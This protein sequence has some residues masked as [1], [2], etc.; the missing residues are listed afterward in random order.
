LVPSNSSPVS[1]FLRDGVLK[2]GLETARAIA[3]FLPHPVPVVV[4]TS[5]R[6]RGV[7]L[8]FL[9]EQGLEVVTAPGIPAD[10]LIQAVGQ[11]REWMARVCERLAAEGA[12]PGGPPAPRPK[13]LVLTAFHQ[14]F[15]V[16][17]L[18]KKQSGCLLMVRGPDAVMVS[19]AIDDRPAVAGVLA[20]FCRDRAGGLLRQALA[21]VSRE[22]G[23]PYTGVTIRAQRTRWGSCTAKGSISLNFTLAFLPW[24]LCRLVLLHELCHTKELN[25][26]VRFWALLATLEPDCRAV[27]A[28]LA[29]ARRYLPLWLRR[30]FTAARR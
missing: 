15:R 11:R 20:G 29:S 16:D 22:A 9:P 5:G 3:A 14:E 25:H 8:R 12:L 1:G 26:A 6:V 17:Y 19:G 10:R 27:D 24:E 28:R 30:E 4:R 18:A 2:N 23:L 7:S 21:A 13:R